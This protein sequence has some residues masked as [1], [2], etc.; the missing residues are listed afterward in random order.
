MKETNGVATVPKGNT[1]GMF[2][3]SRGILMLFV[4]FAHSISHF[5]KYWDRGT[6]ALWMFVPLAVL[7]ILIYGLIPMF[8]L[9]SG[10]GFREQTMKRC[11][12]DRLRYLWKP[13]VFVAFLVTAGAILK[14]VLRGKPIVDAVI[15]QG[16]PFLLGLC[17]GEV[18]I[19]GK[20]VESVGPLWFLVALVGSRIVLNLIFRLENEVL[21]GLCVITLV[22]F[23]TCLP[24]YALIPFCVIQSL[25]C[26]GYLYVG[27]CI[28]KYN[29][30][31][32]RFSKR[33]YIVLI[34]ILVCVFPFGN[35]DVSQNV[36][37]LGFLDFIASCVA[38][39]L[40]CRLSVVGERLQ[41]RITRLFRIIGRYSLYFL[42]VHAVEFF[43]IPWE[44]VAG[45]FKGRALF[46]FIAIWIL[47]LLIDSVGCVIIYKIAKLMRRKH[48]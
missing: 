45:M 41:G 13:Y 31:F 1:I 5:V 42:C 46:G 47:R 34:A 37:K 8:F 23:C 38:G 2:D 27:Y 18:E 25:S 29:L 32:A 36:W 10:Y 44:R 16:A 33:T 3:L 26:A 15:R 21:R 11:I 20:Y 7:G 12:G 28:K 6:L 48:K 35:V 14:A 19:G 39:F 43:V 24:F 4:V 22:A 9:M 17:P 30:L 40:L